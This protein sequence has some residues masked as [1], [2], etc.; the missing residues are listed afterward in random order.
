MRPSAGH[1]CSADWDLYEGFCKT[2]DRGITTSKVD[3]NSYCGIPFL[4]VH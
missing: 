1:N 4:A 3:S 2:E